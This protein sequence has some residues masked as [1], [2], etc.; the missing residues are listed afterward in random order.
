MRKTLVYP[1]NQSING[2]EAML[3]ATNKCTGIYTLMLI[4]VDGCRASRSKAEENRLVRAGS[5]RYSQKV[6]LAFI[7]IPTNTN[8]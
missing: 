3:R 7:P 6:C 4:W 5:C 8:C 2:K 1:I